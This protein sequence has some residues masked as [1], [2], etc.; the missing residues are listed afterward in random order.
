MDSMLEAPRIIPLL[1]CSRSTLQSYRETIQDLNTETREAR[2]WQS[3]LEINRIVSD[4]LSTT[5]V[6]RHNIRD[7]NNQNGKVMR[8]V[9]FCQTRLIFPAPFHL[10]FFPVKFLT[11]RALTALATPESKLNPTSRLSFHFKSALKKGQ[12][13]VNLMTEISF[14]DLGMFW[15]RRN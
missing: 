14:L 10:A 6:S 12:A 9:D 15:L 2:L 4:S 8:L 5:I 3:K 7:S 11:L 13:F 1:T